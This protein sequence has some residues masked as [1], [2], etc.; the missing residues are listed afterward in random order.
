MKPTHIKIEDN[1]IPGEMRQT[2]DNDLIEQM[3]FRVADQTCMIYYKDGHSVSV[4][5]IF[6]GFYN[7]N[8]GMPPSKDGKYIY[9]G[10]WDWWDGLVAHHVPSG[11][12][13]WRLKKGG[14]REIY[15]FDE[16]LIV[17]AEDKGLRKVDAKTGKLLQEMK[18]S[19]HSSFLLDNR[20]IIAFRDGT[21]RATVF[22]VEDG[23]IIKVYPSK[24]VNPN[25]C[26]TFWVESA[27]LEKNVLIIGGREMHPKGRID[28]QQKW[29][30]F[31]RIIDAAFSAVD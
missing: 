21:G 12:V 17:R 18:G 25:N 30:P 19:F 11:E 10:H 3:C 29:I 6:F 9:V 16:F 13:A 8:Y 2:V 22:D 24:E 4:K 26:L 5:I 28:E 14:N 20:Q 1:I 23:S 7:Y 31:E 27:R 15:V